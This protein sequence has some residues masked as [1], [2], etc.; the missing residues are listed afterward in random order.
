MYQST[1]T[2]VDKWNNSTVPIHNKTWRKLSVTLCLPSAESLP[3]DLFLWSNRQLS[4]G[5]HP[6]RA[7]L[8]LRRRRLQLWRLR[9]VRSRRM[10]PH[11]AGRLHGRDRPSGWRRCRGSFWSVR[12]YG[13]SAHLNTR[14][15]SPVEQSYGGPRNK[16]LKITFIK[17]RHRWFLC[18]VELHRRVCRNKTLFAKKN[19]RSNTWID[20]DAFF[21]RVLRREFNLLLVYFPVLKKI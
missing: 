8:I 9:P 6:G 2:S 4:C 10:A 17:L 19:R 7:A 15:I 12:L 5:C 14:Q 18:G 20:A 13:N 11:W 16:N 21:I 1:S 3:Y